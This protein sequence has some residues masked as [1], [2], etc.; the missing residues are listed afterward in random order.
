MVFNYKSLNDNTY[1]DQSS[2]PGIN[3]L[4]QRIG[5][6]KIFSKFDL[7]SGFH[8]VAMAKESIERTTF[9]V[10]GGL[11]EWLV[12]PF[13]LKNAPA[14]FQRKMDKCFEGTENFIASK[15]KT[16][17]RSFLGI[18][19]YSRNY[20][21][22]LS[23]LLGPL[24][25]KTSPHG[26]KRLKASNYEIIR[27]I[28]EKVQNLPDLEIPPEDAY[29][30]IETDGCME[31]WGGIC[32]WK[33]KKFDQKSTKKVCAYASGKFKTIQS[34]IDAEIKLASTLWRN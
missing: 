24:Y 6:A 22:N 28:K 29:I 11:Y 13:G 1:K 17:L 8:Q 3:T 21:P 10:P 15:T 34:T 30:V 18:L 25:E 4:L 31:G 14:M 33:K 26:D 5:N 20:I 27:K 7:K 23:T 2:L 12:M 19:N 16:G 9:L 32:K